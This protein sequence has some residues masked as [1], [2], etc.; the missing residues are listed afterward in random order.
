MACPPK[1]GHV[2]IT[3]RSGGRVQGK[4]RGARS[5]PSLEERARERASERHGARMVVS[6]GTEHA[7][8]VLR[9]VVLWFPGF[10]VPF[11]PGEDGVPG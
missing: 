2:L 3:L 7:L 9:T 5:R 1:V 8:T 11:S 10:S 4:D 6:E